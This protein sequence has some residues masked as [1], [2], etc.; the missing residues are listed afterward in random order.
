MKRKT[1]PPEFL[2]TVTLGNAIELC[3][4]IPDHS[5]DMIFTDPPYPFDF[6]YL[7]A[8][9]GSIATRI[10]KPGGWLFAY[11]GNEHAFKT[12][13][14]LRLCG[15][16]EWYVNIIITHRGA[17][18]MLYYKALQSDYKLCHVFTSG[19]VKPDHPISSIQDGR[20]PEKGYHIWGQDGGL[21]RKMLNYLTHPDGDAIMLDPFTGGGAFVAAAKEMGRQFIGFEVDPQAHAASLRHLADTT[22]PLVLEN[23]FG[24]EIRTPVPVDF[25]K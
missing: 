14:L 23:M 10:L 4:R 18:P 6:F 5:I 25:D 22:P 21:C 24:E 12:E 8:W 1:T 20:M 11:A 2:N 19:R 9:L 16:L 13:S 3:Q 7:Y 15:K 17:A